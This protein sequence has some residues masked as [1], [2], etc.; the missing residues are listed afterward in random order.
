MCSE[1]AVI[2][3]LWPEVPSIILEGFHCTIIWVSI[4]FCKLA[5]RV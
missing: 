4:I 1:H 5:R 2:A 3:F